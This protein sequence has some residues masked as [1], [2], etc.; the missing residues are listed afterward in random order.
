MTNT[1]IDKHCGYDTYRPFCFSVASFIAVEMRCF[2]F[3]CSCS[4]GYKQYPF[5]I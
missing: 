2:M 4:R 1:L 5:L 3:Y